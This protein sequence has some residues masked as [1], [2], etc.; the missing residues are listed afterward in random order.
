MWNL[1]DGFA[2]AGMFNEA[3]VVSDAF[4]R[5]DVEDALTHLCNAATLLARSGRKEGAIERVTKNLPDFPDNPFVLIAS[6]QACG[7]LGEVA[8]ALELYLRALDL[9]EEGGDPEE[10]ESV[11]HWLEDF[12][13]SSRIPSGTSRR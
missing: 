3:V 11:H 4:A 10:V 7:K 9:A 8:S 5:L 13:T 1:A 12:L 6:A 2:D